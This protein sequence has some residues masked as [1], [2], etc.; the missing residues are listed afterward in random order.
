MIE[1]WIDIPGFEN[2]Q[3]SDMGRIRNK[4]TGKIRKQKT[5]CWGYKMINL[6]SKGIRK[7]ISVHKLVMLNFAGDPPIRDNGQRYEVNHKD[8]VKENNSI[9]NLEYVTKSY[10]IKH[11]YEITP[12]KYRKTRS[13]TG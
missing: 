9:L 5:N 2:Y 7:T 13:K 8:G 1:R 10:N 4:K 3:V 12:W 11:S 6:Y